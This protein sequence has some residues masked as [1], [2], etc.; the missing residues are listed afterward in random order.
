MSSPN[1]SF[2]AS[3]T[4][5]FAPGSLLR[6][7]SSVKRKKSATNLH[8]A[9]EEAKQQLQ[10]EG[11]KG[12]ESDDEDKEEKELMAHR[13]TLQDAHR[14][15]KEAQSKRSREE[16]ELHKTVNK[17]LQETTELRDRLTAETA[18]RVAAE[19]REHQLEAKLQNVEDENSGLKSRL[20]SS[21]LK[22]DTLEKQ[23]SDLQE[24]V[25]HSKMQL[26]VAPA[27]KKKSTKVLK[28]TAVGL[29][30]KYEESLRQSLVE[31][32]SELRKLL[33]FN[34]VDRTALKREIV[35]HRVAFAENSTGSGKTAE[36]VQKLEEELMT[37]KAERTRQ[38]QIM[39]SMRMRVQN[40]EK[41]RTALQSRIA[42][43]CATSSAVSGGDSQ[44]PFH[45]DRRTATSATR[46][47]R[48]VSPGQASTGSQPWYPP[49]SGAN[50]HRNTHSPGPGPVSSR[51]T[52]PRLGALRDY[53]S[54]SPSP[55]PSLSPPRPTPRRNPPPQA[56]P[57]SQPRYATPTAS[58]RTHRTPSIRSHS[59]SPPRETVTKTVEHL[60]ELIDELRSWNE[61][62]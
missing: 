41:E 10:L 6:S 4:G 18:S 37:L 34:Y 51:S 17:L 35:R 58:S 12:A 24:E 52:T 7:S 54:K 21:Q 20:I 55:G 39:D 30:H 2:L 13:S 57:P 50:F 14:K 38:Q 40:L 8:L 43:D 49:G 27:A 22:V 1:D 16:S 26:M 11:V 15:A 47:R 29:V 48:S 44:H 32:E 9:R 19:E 60:Q 28:A 3:T 45:N 25:E 33:N 46:S 23:V 36:E 31:S 59:S 61:E 56:T 62:E 42:H 53:H 5:S